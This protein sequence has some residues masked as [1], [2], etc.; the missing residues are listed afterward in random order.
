[1]TTVRTAVF[2]VAGLGTR[3]LPATK[4]VPKELLPIV[5]RP[6]IQFAVDEAREVGI[7]HFIFVTRHRTTAIKDHFDP[8]IELETALGEINSILVDAHTMFSAENR[9]N[10][11]AAIADVAST[12]SQLRSMLE[13]NRGRVEAILGSV[14]SAAGNIDTVSADVK[15][16]VDGLRPDLEAL[17]AKLQSAVS[18]LQEAAAAA[19]GKLEEVDIAQVNEVVENLDLV[20]RNLVEFTDE[21]KKRPYRLI[22]KGKQP[23]K[24]FQ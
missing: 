8:N 10:V 3:F 23:P 15:D 6:L 19:S 2:P 17:T 7:E 14:G 11:D 5:D 4:A 20:S 16:A 12:T 24:D 13:D 9:G 18:S 1:M 22:R 21:I